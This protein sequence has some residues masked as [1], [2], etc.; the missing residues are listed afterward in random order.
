MIFRPRPRPVR[1][2]KRF[3]VFTRDMLRVLSTKS[4]ASPTSPV[5]HGHSRDH[6]VLRESFRGSKDGFLVGLAREFCT[7]S[8]WNV[9]SMSPAE[10]SML[11]TGRKM[12]KL[13]PNSVLR[14][15]RHCTQDGCREHVFQNFERTFDRRL[16]TCLRHLQVHCRGLGAFVCLLY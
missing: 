1:R 4:P 16:K 6:F 14:K 13:V 8:T 15:S 12:S 9:V 11:F 10:D 7:P 2:L 5:T 3:P